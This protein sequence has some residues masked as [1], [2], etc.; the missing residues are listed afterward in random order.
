MSL[1]IT[2]DAMPKGLAVRGFWKITHAPAIVLLLNA[3]LNIER[4]KRR[5]GEPWPAFCPLS[6]RIIPGIDVDWTLG[7]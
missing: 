3:A 1:W 7:R 4:S 6:C 2:F 5:K